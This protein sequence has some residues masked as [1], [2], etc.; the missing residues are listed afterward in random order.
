VFLQGPTKRKRPPN[1]CQR[2]STCFAA[3]PSLFALDLADMNSTRIARKPYGWLL[4][5][6][7]RDFI[8]TGNFAEALVGQGP[9][10]AIEETGEIFE[11][12]SANP[13]KQLAALEK[14]LGMTSSGNGY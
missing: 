5:Y 8:E 6:K 3:R 14:N 11:L 2:A 10:V 13:E 1:G 12:G 7:S 4:Y 9:V